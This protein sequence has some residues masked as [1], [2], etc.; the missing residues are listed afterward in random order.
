MSGNIRLHPE[1]GVNPTLPVCFWCG[2]DTGEIALLGAAYKGEA[3]RHLVL[4]KEPCQKCQDNWAQ[5]IVLFEG[6]QIGTETQMSGRWAVVKEEAIERLFNPPELVQQ[7]LKARKA[8]VETA[9]FE[10]LFVNPTE[11][12]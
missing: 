4:N 5:G 6:E 10:A 12:S 7:V 8:V 9:L 3:P 2:E 11:E 1:H